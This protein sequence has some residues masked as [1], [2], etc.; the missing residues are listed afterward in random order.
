MEHPEWQVAAEVM[1]EIL[2]IRDLL[3][4]WLDRFG[5]EALEEVLPDELADL[6]FPEEVDERLATLYRENADVR[7]HLD[8]EYKRFRDDIAPPRDHVWWWL[9][10]ELYSKQIH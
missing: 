10:A 3:A 4:E 8:E 1:E 7:Q 6:P 2:F 5:E 9:D